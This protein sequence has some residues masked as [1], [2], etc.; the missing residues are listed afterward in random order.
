MENKPAFAQDPTLTARKASSL[1]KKELQARKLPF[2]T[3]KARTVSFADLARCSRIFVGIKGWQTNF[4][5][6][7][8][9][10]AFS[11]SKGF[12]IEVLSHADGS[13]VFSGS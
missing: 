10:V 4:D 6:Y 2:T 13:P 11:A 9:L 3:L 5:A 8:D 1:L 7:K 12:Y